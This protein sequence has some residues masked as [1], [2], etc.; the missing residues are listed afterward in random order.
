[1]YQL[2][3]FTTLWGNCSICVLFE[4]WILSTCMISSHGA[5]LLLTSLVYQNWPPFIFREVNMGS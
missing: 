5:K 4:V 1:M 3:K 2:P